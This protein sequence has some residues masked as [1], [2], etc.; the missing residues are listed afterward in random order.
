MNVLIIGNIKPF[1][2]IF[3]NEAESVLRN[4][5]NFVIN[6]VK[7]FTMSMKEDSYFLSR[8]L[9]CIANVDAVYFL[10]DYYLLNYASLLQI[11]VKALKLN[12]LNTQFPSTRIFAFSVSEIDSHWYK[13]FDELINF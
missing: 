13:E 6:P 7:A 9:E 3:F 12:I 1:N 4:E 5:G 10:P 11:V 2:Q 8:Y